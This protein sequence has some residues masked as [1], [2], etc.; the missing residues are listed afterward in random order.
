MN[1][2]T[3]WNYLSDTKRLIGQSNAIEDK[4]PAYCTTI[5]PPEIPAGKEA[6][7]DE[8]NQ[9]WYLQD[10]TTADPLTQNIKVYGYMPDTLIYIGSADALASDLPPN[11]TTIAPA[12]APADGYVLTFDTQEQVWQETEDHRGETVYS[13][14]TAQSVY[15]MAIGPYPDGTT[16]VAPAVPFPVWNGDEWVTDTTAQANSNVQRNV[17]A[18][19]ELMQSVN[20]SLC[21]LNAAVAQS[22]AL[23][24]D[25]QGTLSA[26]QLFAI[27]LAQ[28]IQTADLTQSDLVFPE[29]EPALIAYPFVLNPAY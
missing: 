28:F 18:Y 9:S 23:T 27:E 17:A 24:T 10:M 22:Q 2:V 5:E 15:I 25:Q 6:F 14:D 21:P 8:E 29:I 19:R 13:T 26:L 1:I 4:L 11:C 16:T 3:I 7:F 12:A 20:L